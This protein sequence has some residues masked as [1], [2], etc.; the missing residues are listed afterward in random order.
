MKMSA[1]SQEVKLCLVVPCYNEEQRLPVKSFSNFL[2]REGVD[3]LFVNDGSTDKTLAVLENL[4]AKFENASCL[5]LDKNRGK[6]EAV[7]RGFLYADKKGSYSH[8]GYWDADLAT[9]LSEVDNFLSVIESNS[10]ELVMGSR[11]L[12]L[13]GY[14]ER[15]FIRH[16]LGRLFATVASL[17]L[18]IP[19]YDTQCGAKVFKSSLVEK[20]F[21]EKFVSYWIFDVELLFRLRNEKR[22]Q[23]VFADRVYELPLTKWRD[24]EGS[25]LGLFDFLKAPFELFKIRKKYGP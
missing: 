13:G 21:S 11:I 17:V 1:V 16:F 25:K 8:I 14:I 2:G 6:A 19:V 10:Y 9:P 7:R 5:D 23:R 3:L 22:K 15:S 24:I 18:K 20:I 12:R 4:C